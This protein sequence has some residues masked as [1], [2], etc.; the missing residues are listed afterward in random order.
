MT[1][2]TR[3]WLAV[4][5]L[6]VGCG[7]ET[8]QSDDNFLVDGTPE[9]RW[10]AAGYITRADGSAGVLC[11]ATLI[12]PNVAMTTAHCIYRNREAPLA[13]GV[14]EL[15]DKRQFGVEEI[16]YHPNVHLEAEGFIDPIHTL[17]MYDLAYVVLSEA[18]PDVE[19]AEL[20]TSKPEA[21][22]NVKLIAYGLGDDNAVVRKSVDGCILFNAQLGSDA[23]FEVMPSY[24][25]AICNADGDEGH[26]AI[27]ARDDLTPILTG[28]Y[29]G[30]VTQSLTDCRKY[31][32]FLN[33][34]EAT[35][36]HLAFYEDAIQRGADAMAP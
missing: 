18:V 30:S 9:G 20:G 33:G 25:G 23:I 27:V 26:A 10:E 19:P 8:S 14:G 12:A 13:F 22:C 1:S 6:L 32:Q 15:S 28:I 3:S 35:F 4:S 24:Q 36:G 21:E 31:V 7:G 2:A 17:R 34:Y 16:H 11:G 29:V 5:C